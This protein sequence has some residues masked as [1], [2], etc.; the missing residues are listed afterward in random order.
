M[1]RAIVLH[2]TVRGVSVGLALVA[3]SA[4]LMVRQAPFARNVFAVVTATKWAVILT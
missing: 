2:G 3:A 1:K 4:C